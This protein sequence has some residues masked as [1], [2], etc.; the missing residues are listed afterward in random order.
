MKYSGLAVFWAMNVPTQ[1]K[2][3]FVGNKEKGRISKSH[4]RFRNASPENT[5]AGLT[6]TTEKGNVNKVGITFYI[7][8]AVGSTT[9]ESSQS[10]SD[11]SLSCQCCFPVSVGLRLIDMS[12][13]WNR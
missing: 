1:E 3:L 13:F 10:L 4:N 2:Q 9:P 8:S 11:S 7:I 12:F 6:K 5:E